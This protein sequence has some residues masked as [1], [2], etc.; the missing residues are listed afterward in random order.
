MNEEKRSPIEYLAQRQH[1]ARERLAEM[2]SKFARHE[3][4]LFIVWY[5]EGADCGIIQGLPYINALNYLC[6]PCTRSFNVFNA[7]DASRKPITKP[8]DVDLNWQT[9][10]LLHGLFRHPKVFVGDQSV[11]QWIKTIDRLNEF[12]QILGRDPSTLKF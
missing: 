5:E 1:L 3:G 10:N 4:E 9:D 12:C 6:I 7:R 2:M 11:L 8:G